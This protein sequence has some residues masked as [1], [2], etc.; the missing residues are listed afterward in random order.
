MVSSTT[1][2]PSASTTMRSVIYV[3]PFELPPVYI[4]ITQGQNIGEMLFF[5]LLDF[6]YTSY[7]PILQHH[8][9]AMGMEGAFGEQTPNNTLR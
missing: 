8:L 9:D 1:G 7:L 5:L 2:Q 3:A 6:L 4:C